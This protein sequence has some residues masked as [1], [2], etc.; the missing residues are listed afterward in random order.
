[1]ENYSYAS[2]PD[3]VHSSPRSREIEGENSSWEDS[4]TNYKVKFMCSYDGKIHPRPNDNQLSYVGGNTKILTVD[5]NIRFSAIISKLASLNN[6][7]V[8]FKYQLPGEDLDAL[9][10]VTNDEDLEHMML[11]YDCL[12]RGSPKP[13]RLRLFL[14]PL[15][16]QISTNFDPPQSD[17]KSD[18]QWFVDALNSGPIQSIEPSSPA[19]TAGTPAN[20]DFLLDFDKLSTGSASPSPPVTK[21]PDP[22]PESSDLVHSPASGGI[23][24]TRN[25]DREMR[26]ESMETQRQIQE[27]QRSQIASQ[28]QTLFQTRNEENLQHRVF[29]GDYY[30]QKQIPVPAG[31][32]PERQMGGYTSPAVAGAESGMYMVRPPA[33]VYQQQTMRPVTGQVGQG[34]YAMPR[35]MPE[36]YRESPVYGIG[37]TQPQPGVVWPPT[38]DAGYA[39]MAYNSAGRPVFYSAPSG[40]VPTYQTSNEATAKPTQGF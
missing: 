37:P 29:P 8:S 21:L 4:P 36:V 3:S 12:V 2:Y 15:N 24:N 9:I 25:E 35:M 7:D 22:V 28:E 5:R 39:Q 27:I 18:Q 26:G 31:Y 17:L 33:G 19:K 23:S 40:A 14:F 34:Y 20:P 16:P 32:W 38:G 6:S 10:S 30:M 13:P 1:M 11:E